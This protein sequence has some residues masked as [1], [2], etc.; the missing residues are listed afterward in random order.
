MSRTCLHSRHS[1]TPSRHRSNGSWKNAPWRTPPVWR[2]FKGQ[3]FLYEVYVD[4]AEEAKQ[5]G[6]NAFAARDRAAAV[7]S[8]DDALEHL[9][10]CICGF[11]R[12]KIKERT[13]RR[14]GL[15]AIIFANRAAAY[16]LDG[17]GQDLMAALHDG[18]M[19][20]SMNPG[21]AKA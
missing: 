13:K 21:Y 2:F 15:G 4:L 3:D 18:Q 1:S 7:K 5:A 6:N 14:E 20:A 19:A 17:E 12:A 10:A 11:R 8:Y 16:L 9:N